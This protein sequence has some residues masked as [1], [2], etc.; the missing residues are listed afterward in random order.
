MTARSRTRRE[1]AAA[2]APALEPQSGSRESTPQSPSGPHRRLRLPLLPTL[3]AAAG[4][5]L[6]ATA[7][8]TR[9]PPGPP[10]E[11]E[12]AARFTLDIPAD[13]LRVINSW[14]RFFICYDLTDP[15][16]VDLTL[17]ANQ[18]ATG[19]LDFPGEK[20][21]VELPGP[22]TG[23]SPPPASAAEEELIAAKNAVLGA[24]L[25]ERMASVRAQCGT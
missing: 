7:W 25:P 8:T 22:T 15:A 4:L 9:L 6:L 1:R 19:N 2:D 24:A 13:R 16:I 21:I 3:A 5:T 12:K 14:E 17:R 10:R 11:A 20:V 23:A 18:R